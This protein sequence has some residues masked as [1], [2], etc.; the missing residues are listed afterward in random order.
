MEE[1]S[2]TPFQVSRYFKE[3]IG[4]VLET[5][6]E[7]PQGVYQITYRVG[8]VMV[9]AQVWRD[10]IPEIHPEFSAEDLEFLKHCNVTAE[11][12]TGNVR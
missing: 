4:N 8:D 2:L 10:P 1:Q 11:E 12:S 7:N 3:H 9:A 6:E 5:L